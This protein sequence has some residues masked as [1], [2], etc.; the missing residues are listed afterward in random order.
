VSDPLVVRGGR[1]G[2][3]AALEEL[4]RAARALTAAAEL[5]DDAGSSV[6]W[7]RRE[8]L[9]ATAASPGTARAAQAELE[10]LL[11]G[12]ASL[13]ALAE[14]LRSLAGG[15][16][17]AA[18][19]YED[20]ERA[21][22]GALRSVLAVG[23]A[24]A[25]DHPVATV[26][27]SVLLAGWL[28]PRA[29]LAA[30][31][32][33]LAG[34]RLPGPSRLTV[35]VAEHAVQLVGG[36]GH[37]GAPGTG[38]TTT[39]PAVRAAG[40]LAGATAVGGLATPALRGRPLR[41]TARLAAAGP[42]APPRDAA[43]VLAGVAD[44]Y[45]RAG[46]APGTV[47]VDRL[48]HPDGSRSW[49]VTIPGTQQAL[50]WGTSGNPMDMLTNVRLL[51]ATSD[52]GTRLVTRALDQAGARPDEPVLLAGHSQG[53]MVA[54]ALAGSAAFTARHPVAAVLTAGSPVATHA[55]PARTPALHLEHR[56]DL[57]PALDGWRNPDQPDRTTAVR[58]LASSSAPADRWAARSP[59]G[60]HGV[61]AYAR[62]ATAVHDAGGRS[63][64]GWERAAAQVLGGPGTTAY[65]REF[66]GERVGSGAA[67]PS[68]GGPGDRR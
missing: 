43:D 17:G 21:A 42:V 57:V 22:V 55:V 27:G 5:L 24:V 7:A 59:G 46:G 66:T 4:R 44:L 2:T 20:A 29:L 8:G 60:A 25:G 52:E 14:T 39:T 11:R 49:V 45:P 19:V 40:Y 15:L 3:R 53:G 58:D 67:G 10:P 13:G 51:A 23:G 1:G 47:G 56:Q 36:L 54:M 33:R 48:D 41:V 63:V 12:P 32:L 35:D 62:T 9:A 31:V 18:E 38:T 65:H 26:A 64:R 68:G 28:L 50:S 37:G 6:A 30:T 61:E 16:H 34:G